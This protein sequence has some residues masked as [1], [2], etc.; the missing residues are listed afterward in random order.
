MKLVLLETG[1]PEASPLRALSG[2]RIDFDGKVPH[3]RPRLDCLAFRVDARGRSVVHSGDSGPSASLT[4][5]AG[6]ADILIHMYFQPSGERLSKEWTDGS[7]GHLEVA[8]CAGEAGVSTLIPTHLLPR[9]E[10]P[11]A[12]K[13]ARREMS[14]IYGGRIELGKDL[15]VL[16]L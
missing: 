13:R 16:K 15:R 10:E 8:K 6:G 9:L 7:S 12:Q 4:A 5:M 3:A 2:C 14:E 11:D 1:T